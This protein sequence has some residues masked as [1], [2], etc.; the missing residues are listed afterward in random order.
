[1][2]DQFA[3]MDLLAPEER[4]ARASARQ[5]AEKAL[6]PHIAGWWDAGELPVREVMRGL[7]AQGFLGPMTPP[8]Y[9]GS[10]ASSNLYGALMY[11]LDRVD[12]GIRS[13]ASVQG[14]LV[15]YPIHAYGSE[16]Q[17]AQ[18]LPGL[19]SGELIG[20]FGLTE[21]SGGSDP[22]A[23]RTRARLA[24]D[25]TWRLTGEKSFIS[26]ADHDAT[27]QI[28]HLVLALAEG[29]GGVAPNLFLVPKHLSDGTRNAA[30]VTGIERKMGLHGSPTCALSLDGASGWRIGGHG[31][32]LRRMFTMMNLMR[33]DVAIQ[34]AGLAQAATQAA[35]SRRGST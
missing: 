17:R 16:E 23:M 7:G 19:A 22:G 32:G 31:E 28:L 11:E 34:S 8:E 5:Y 14:S 2:F 10:G 26:Y 35:A 25:G 24:E 4:Q 15:M 6:M 21:E 27:P 1:M 20:C 12:S 13:A 29:E 33:L 9:G 30:H 18:Y 3:V